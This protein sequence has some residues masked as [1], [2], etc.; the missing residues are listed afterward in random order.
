MVDSDGLTIFTLK[1][2]ASIVPCGPKYSYLCD[3]SVTYGLNTEGLKLAAADLAARAGHE[4][5]FDFTPLLRVS[6]NQ[7]YVLWVEG[8]APARFCWRTADKG[9]QTGICFEVLP[10]NPV[11]EVA[12][13]AAM[14]S[15]TGAI[16]P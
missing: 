10:D 8:M 3:T 16:S 9:K 7:G 1:S 2:R 4:F 6:G 12:H 5:P 15:E 13:L 11:E 14:L